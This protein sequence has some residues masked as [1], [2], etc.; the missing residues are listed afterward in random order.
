M[1]SDADINTEIERIANLPSARFQVEFQALAANMKNAV[2]IR[3]DQLLEQRLSSGGMGPNGGYRPAKVG[4]AAEI[5][6]L[7]METQKARLMAQIMREMEHGPGP[8]GDPSVDALKTELERLRVA[9]ERDRDERR[10]EE[11][12]RQFLEQS[13]RPVQEQLKA[14]ESRLASDPQASEQVRALQD[15]IRS[16]RDGQKEEKWAS[17][18]RSLRDAIAVMPKDSANTEQFKMLAE[19]VSSMARARNEGDSKFA[20][21]MAKHVERQIDE[22]RHHVMS[23]QEGDEL[24]RVERTA[25]FLRQYSSEKEPTTTDKL[26]TFGEKVIPQLKPMIEASAQRIQT[27]GG[28]EAEMRVDCNYCHHPF[29]VTETQ[30]QSGFACPHCET[31]FHPDGSWT[32]PQSGGPAP[33]PSSPMPQRAAVRVDRPPMVGPVQQG[34]VVHRPSPNMRFKIPS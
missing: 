13:L 33:P 10:R 19:M 30:Q 1:P 28:A 6:E 27:P 8:T 15:E 18:I 32:P 29:R 22:L 23:G 7:F 34:P 3:R 9:Q 21:F 12:R 20:E 26:L 5:Q 11:E 16:L 17:E 4:M 2:A 31:K 14:L 25:K 24:D